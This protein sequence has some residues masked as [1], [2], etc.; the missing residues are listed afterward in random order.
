[1]RDWGRG[2]SDFV[3]VSLIWVLPSR[4]AYEAKLGASK[5]P[6]DRSAAPAVTG[7]TVRGD[8]IWKAKRRLTNVTGRLHSQ[9]GSLV[10]LRVQFGHT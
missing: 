8:G 7:I 1:M 4:L 5:S 9:S 3:R 2:K 10:T 6:Y